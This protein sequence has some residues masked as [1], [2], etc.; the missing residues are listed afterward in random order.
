MKKQLL[1]TMAILAGTIPGLADDN[2]TTAT[3][4]NAT[5]NTTRTMTL[6]LNHENDYVAFQVDLTLPEGTSV[7]AVTAKA[8]LNDA[9]TADNKTE[10]TIGGESYSTAFNVPFNQSGTS[11]RILGYNCGN[12]PV[13]GSTGDILLTVTL[14]STDAV[15][16][17]A[18]TIKAT[19]IRFVKNNE[20]LDEVSLAET[21]SDSRL[22]GDVVMDGT[23]DGKDIQAVANIFSGVENSGTI[24]KFAGDITG[25]GEF[26]G[27][28]IQAVANIFSGI[29]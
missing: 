20:T 2:V 27:K 28:D 18:S 6:A 8:A 12:A 23:V 4:G 10:V 24:D 19:N 1:L 14:T 13:A 21:T 7:T 16:Y 25:E 5:G 9:K 26:D 29:K 17:D 3:Y 15:A 22:W 11:C